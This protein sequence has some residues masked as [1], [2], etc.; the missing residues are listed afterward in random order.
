MKPSASMP[1][2]K[3][4]ECHPVEPRDGGMRVL[5][6]GGGEGGM[7]GWR[8]LEGGSEAACS[9]GRSQSAGTVGVVPSWRHAA[10]TH[11]HFLRRLFPCM[12]KSLLTGS[13]AA[14]LRR[15]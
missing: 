13:A 14:C 2:I 10:Q 9:E 3:D 6:E 8:D 1:R 5:R 11:K 15:E 7:E 12:K 4:C